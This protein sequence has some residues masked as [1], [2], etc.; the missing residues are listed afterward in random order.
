[1]S[2]KSW[3]VA[4]IVEMLTV[5]VPLAPALIPAS[6][7]TFVPLAANGEYVRPPSTDIVVATPNA[8]EFTAKVKSS[9]E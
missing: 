9:L 5:T 7:E 4:R 6:N 3:P 2:K 8:E 1:M